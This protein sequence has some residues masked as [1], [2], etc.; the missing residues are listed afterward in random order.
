MLVTTGCANTQ[1][2]D[3]NFP[4]GTRIGILNML[5]ADA[6]HK[7]IGTLRLDSFTKTYAVDWNIPGYIADKIGDILRA[8]SRFNVIRITP[9]IGQ[10]DT[11]EKL[12]Y[13]ITQ[14]RVMDDAGK[15]IE[16]ISRKHRLHVLVIIK[17]YNDESP[18]DIAGNPIFVNGYGLLTRQTVLGG[19]SKIFPLKPNQML[20]YAHI[21]VMSFSTSPELPIGVIRNGSPKQSKSSLKNFRWPANIKNIPSKDFDILEPIIRE[22]ADQAIK[23]GMNWV[24]IQ[25]QTKS[26][27]REKDLR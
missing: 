21:G 5:E 9:T 7:H 15:Y 18:Y 27:E 19:I 12:D 22:Y 3:V 6:T 8:D 24:S 2:P 13:V 11:V 10:K 26:L 25:S 14:K 20:A 16:S 17:S 1:T 23:N 4:A